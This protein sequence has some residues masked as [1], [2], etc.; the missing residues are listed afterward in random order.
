MAAKLWAMSG[1]A[2]AVRVSRRSRAPSARI[3]AAVVVA[4]G[5][6]LLA[7]ACG[8]SAGS[9]VARLGSTTDR[10]APSSSTSAGAGGSASS[11]SA[12]AYSACMRS[13]GV[14]NFPDPTSSGQLP[15]V[16]PQQLGVSSSQLQSA[17]IACRQLLPTGVSLQQ[18]ESECLQNHDCPPALVQQMMTADRKLARCLRTHGVPDFPDPVDDGPAGPYFPISRVGI[19][20][21]ASHTTQFMARLSQCG[22]LVGD[23]APESF[24]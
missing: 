12:L 15:K 8:G 5:L 17:Q 6:A 24:G 13:H 7:A 14:R 20:D 16:G 21:A 9:H 2:R 11:P 4:A 3:A 22:R 1:C 19:S 18:R 10:N 23:N